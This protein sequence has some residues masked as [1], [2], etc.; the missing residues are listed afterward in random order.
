MILVNKPFFPPID[1]YKDMLNKVW[2][3]KYLTN[4]GPLHN[5]LKARLAQ[6]FDTNVEL[7]VNGH[8]ALDVAIKALELSGEVITTPFTFASTTQAIVTNGLTP[9][10]CDVERHTYNID[11][12]KIEE[13]ITDKTTA[14]IAVHVFGYPCDVDK[15]DKIAKKYGLKVIYDAA[16][17][18]DVSINNVPIVKYGDI[19]MLSFHATKVFHTIEGGALCFNDS[20]LISKLNA[21][22]NFGM[23]GDIVGYVGT[24]AKMNEMQA[25]MG[26][27]NLNYINDIIDTRQ[28]HYRQYYNNL[29]SSSFKLSAELDNI[30]HNY[31]YFPLVVQNNAVRDK[32]FDLLKDNG[33]QTRK[34]FY[35]LTKH[36]LWLNNKDVVPVAEDVAS[37]ILCLPLYFDLNGDEIDYICE[38]LIKFEK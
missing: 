35:P 5:E 15:I 18:F 20:S 12:D 36:F 37:K 23:E 22:R 24:N 3:N 34:Y 26:L 33:I 13:L 4:C 2:E 14:I 38:N 9:V 27:L 11:A 29:K 6:R 30:K 17:A 7:F 19:S 25:A 1:K 8:L 21:I 31:S 28:R 10:F 32:L 16:H